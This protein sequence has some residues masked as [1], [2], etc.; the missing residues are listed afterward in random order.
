[1]SHT[2]ALRRLEQLLRAHEALTDAMNEAA[3]DVLDAVKAKKTRSPSRT[4]PTTPYRS[5][6]FERFVRRKWM[7][8]K[9][10]ETR[11]NARK[12]LG[13]GVEHGLVDARVAEE[14]LREFDKSS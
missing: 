1:M 4:G 5:V 14:I 10:E 9:T 2:K 13:D 6:D 3:E 12:L 7:L 8:A 11:A